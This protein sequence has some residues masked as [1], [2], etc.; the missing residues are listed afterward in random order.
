MNAKTLTFK[1]PSVSAL[2]VGFIFGIAATAVAVFMFLPTG[3]LET[4][5]DRFW[6]VAEQK[7]AVAL[8]VSL[9]ISYV[10]SYLQRRVGWIETVVLPGSQHNE[11]A[12]EVVE[13]VLL[14]WKSTPEGEPMRLPDAPVL[15]FC[16][17]TLQSSAIRSGASIV[18]F[19]IIFYAMLH[20]LAP[21]F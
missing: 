21:L 4:W 19:G 1:M 14:T 17:K 12:L 18:Q 8:I 6:G 11:E 20:A 2:L 15:D 9:I 10:V 5:R 3:D 13:V 7:T 16:G